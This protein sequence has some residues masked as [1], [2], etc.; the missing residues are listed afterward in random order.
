MCNTGRA[1]T[2]TGAGTGAGTGGTGAGTALFIA[3]LKVQNERK[4]ASS[5]H[6]SFFKMINVGTQLCQIL[7]CFI[8]SPCCVRVNATLY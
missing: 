7:E 8:L 4:A 6:G 1:L 5:F 3:L 2:G